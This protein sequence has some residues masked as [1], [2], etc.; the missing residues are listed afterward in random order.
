MATKWSITRRCTASFSSDR[1]VFIR[2]HPRP[3]LNPLLFYT[4]LY[5]CS[6]DIAHKLE[7]LNTVLT[8]HVPNRD[9]QQLAKLARVWAKWTKKKNTRPDANWTIR[10][11]EA[12]ASIINMV[13]VDGIGDHDLSRELQKLAKYV[14]VVLVAADRSALYH[15]HCLYYSAAYHLLNHRQ[16]SIN[17]RALAIAPFCWVLPS[18]V[19]HDAVHSRGPQSV[20][21]LHSDDHDVRSF[22]P[23]DVLS[24]KGQ[25]KPS[26]APR[27][28]LRALAGKDVKLHMAP[29]ATQDVL[30]R[31]KANKKKAQLANTSKTKEKKK[32]KQKSGR[33][34]GRITD[35]FGRQQ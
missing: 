31:V 27:V 14:H 5:K 28:D 35:F 7:I 12:L 1:D 17:S 34:N 20:P 19:H 9:N 2:D 15:P 18:A 8:K 23:L 32:K 16:Y 6:L 22:F 24:Y 33:V 21:T 26:R 30:H 4:P 29:Q 25:S 3:P 11:F 13:V 10:N